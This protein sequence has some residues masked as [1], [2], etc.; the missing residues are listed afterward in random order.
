M[1]KKIN[2]IKINH[3]DLGDIEIH[4]SL[5][6]KINDLIGAIASDYSKFS[7]Y[8]ADIILND[9]ET[10]TLERLNVIKPE[11]VDVG[12]IKTDYGSKNYINIY[13]NLIVSREI[14]CY[15]SS[16]HSIYYE[17]NV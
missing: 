11:S 1:N 10:V 16:I 7:F 3:L 13:K 8:F 14:I 17:D 9:N 4:S 2:K 6:K 5:P 15:N 12:F